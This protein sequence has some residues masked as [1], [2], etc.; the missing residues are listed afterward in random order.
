MYRLV[1]SIVLSALVLTLPA[2]GS[3]VGITPE[4]AVEALVAAARD[5]QAALGR[6]LRLQEADRD[7]AEAEVVR[8][9]E[10]AAQELIARRDVAEAE[11]RA[12]WLA[13]AV[14]ET[15]RE[16]ARAET[17]VVEARASL[18][19]GPAPG[20]ERRTADHVAYGGGGPWSLAR[21]PALDRFFTERFGRPLP[22]SAYGQTRLHADMGFDHRHAV[23]VA[24]H[25]DTAEGRA[26]VAYLKSE[27]IPFIAFRA[28]Q[29]GASTGAH[30]HIGEPSPRR[31]TA[32]PGE[33]SS[34]R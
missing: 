2:S 25:P 15:R 14:D 11:E 32:P 27:R 6:L 17:L 24:V 31:P 4:E 23:D 10:L 30:V 8:R 9:R 21:L 13:G 22:V 18:T 28:A 26:L 16:M 5:H 3:T 34:S 1:A 33:R 12:A 29:P 7:R 19:I 20:Q